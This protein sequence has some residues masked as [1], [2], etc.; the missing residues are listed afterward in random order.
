MI[1]SSRATAAVES[2]MLISGGSPTESDFRKVGQTIGAS[3]RTV[4][5]LWQ[6]LVLPP[7]QPAVGPAAQAALDGCE[8]SQLN[9]VYRSAPTGHGWWPTLSDLAVIAAHGN[10]ATAHAQLVKESDVTGRSVPG[11]VQFT[12]RLHECLTE[13]V[14]AGVV[15]GDAAA[16]EQVQL[17][18][19]N[20]RPARLAV[21]EVDAFQLPINVTPTR[22][23][24]LIKPW[25]LTMVD[26][27]TRAA[28][29]WLLL[30]KRPDS[31]DFKTLLALLFTGFTCDDGTVIGGVPG[32]IVPDNGSEFRGADVDAALAAF[33][34]TKVALPPYRG[35]LKGTVERLGRTVQ[36][37]VIATLPGNVH[38]P[39]TSRRQRPWTDTD[40]I[41]YLELAE[42][43]D[44]WFAAYNQAHKHPALARRTPQQVW[45]AD[46]T[47]VVRVDQT[48]LLADLLPRHPRKVTKKGVTV[49]DISYV[50]T[51]LA[52]G[53]HVLVGVLPGHP[54]TVEVFDSDGQWLC[55]ADR[56]DAMPEDARDQLLTSR[57]R[58]VRAVDQ[59]LTSSTAIRDTNHAASA[60]P[61]GG[62][63]GHSLV[64][65]FDDEDDASDSAAPGA[66]ASAGSE[67]TDLFGD[68]S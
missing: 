63:G 38:G 22:G 24:R 44:A 47:P 64:D 45:C 40:P 53:Q 48:V 19:R 59:A 15:R 12:R 17:Y 14:Y 61:S 33:G 54:E 26:R 3:A 56:A 62:T 30:P 1:A 41:G 67:L 55:T 29:A 13:A 4:R 50:T 65:L 9:N 10:L 6:Q 57:R 11:Y 37:G 23:T 52:A 20:G 16:T 35:H 51:G 2:L 28:P 66:A 8:P 43:L 25:L 31:G 7:A 32:S 39:K 42:R 27:G 68:P 18:C 34:V 60:V 21:V 5:R 49:D 58:Q 46:P 36:E